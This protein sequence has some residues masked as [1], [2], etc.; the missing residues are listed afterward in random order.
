MQAEMLLHLRLFREVQ[1]LSAAHRLQRTTEKALK[2]HGDKIDASDRGRIETA[3]ADLKKSMEGEDAEDMR[4]K[5]EEL[6]NCS[7]K[8]AE[9]LYSQA[10]QNPGGAAG[11]AG[12]AAS[13]G[14]GSDGGPEVVDAEFEEMDDNKK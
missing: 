11:A 14:K 3:L 1:Q 5:T 7:H 10:Q 2:E 9:I 12:A 13:S 8:L 4:K 6:A